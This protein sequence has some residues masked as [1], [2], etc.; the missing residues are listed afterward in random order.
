MRTI[1]LLAALFALGANAA[2][3]KW[4]DEK[5]QTQYG[6]IPPSGIAATKM[7]ASTGSGMAAPPAGEKA[8]DEGQT[9]NGAAQQKAPDKDAREARCKFER[10]QLRILEGDVPVIVRNDKGEATPIDETKREAAKALVRDN[11]KK[12]C[13]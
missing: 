9:A 12:Y 5:G 13:S 11:I 1:A 2:I 10:E 3:Y 7:G 8:K 4:V 6:E